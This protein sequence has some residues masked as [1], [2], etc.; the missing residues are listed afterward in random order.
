MP[1]FI[2]PILACDDQ[3]F[4]LGVAGSRSML[5]ASKAL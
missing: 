5:A 2:P 3:S 1:D 4:A